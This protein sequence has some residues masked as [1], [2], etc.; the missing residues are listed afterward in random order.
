VGSI[1]VEPVGV[2]GTSPDQ[3]RPHWASPGVALDDGL[4][5]YKLIH[6]TRTEMVNPESAKAME[7]AYIIVVIG[8]KAVGGT[9]EGVSL[10]PRSNLQGVL[11][12]FGVIPAQIM[13]ILI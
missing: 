13:F 11:F 7:N 8:D 9:G 3:A 10:D 6:R 12:K 5:S 4:G 2:W 1:G